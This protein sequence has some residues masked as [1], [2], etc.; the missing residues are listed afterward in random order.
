MTSLLGSPLW[1]LDGA[2]TAD[3][4]SPEDFSASDIPLNFFTVEFSR[5]SALASWLMPAAAELFECDLESLS[6]E[7]SDFL[8]EF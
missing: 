1:L 4:L 8:F 3:D 5:L 2:V 6:L 7:G